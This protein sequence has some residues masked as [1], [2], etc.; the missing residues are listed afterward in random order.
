MLKH[1]SDERQ[2]DRENPPRPFGLRRKSGHSSLSALTGVLPQPAASASSGLIFA[3]NAVRP[4]SVNRW[5]EKAGLR[6]DALSSQVI[7]AL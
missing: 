4:N 7:D 5:D 1:F 2:S 3:R 6:R